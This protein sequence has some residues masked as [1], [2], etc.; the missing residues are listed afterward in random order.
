MSVEIYMQHFA[1]EI[2]GPGESEGDG[3]D[4]AEPTEAEDRVKAEPDEPGS[5]GVESKAGRSSARAPPA[6]ARSSS[7]RQAEFA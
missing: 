4:E 3:D 6:A 1:Q 2:W 7:A 5:A